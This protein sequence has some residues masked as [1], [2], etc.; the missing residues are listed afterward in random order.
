MVGTA[1]EGRAGSPKDLPR[2]WRLNWRLN[3]ANNFNDSSQAAEKIYRFAAHRDKLHDWLA[4]PGNHNGFAGSAHLAQDP[5]AVPSKFAGRN[6]FQLFLQSLWPLE[7]F[8]GAGDFHGEIQQG[9]LHTAN[10]FA[11]PQFLGEQGQEAVLKIADRA[12]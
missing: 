3:I 10:Y 9:G 7:S 6:C 2:L 12:E 4:I 8:L 1:S 5:E 11:G